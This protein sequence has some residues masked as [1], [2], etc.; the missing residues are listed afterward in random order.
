MK[1]QP[2]QIADLK[3][4]IIIARIRELDRCNPL[5]HHLIEKHKPDLVFT[6]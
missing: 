4:R 6:A 2:G 1:L 3:D 5:A